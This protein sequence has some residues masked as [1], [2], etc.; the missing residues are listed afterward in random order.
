MLTVSEYLPVCYLHSVLSILK[1]K[2]ILSVY[3]VCSWDTVMILWHEPLILREQRSPHDE[4]DKVSLG[5]I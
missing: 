4:N 3:L 1:P 2:N 5:I